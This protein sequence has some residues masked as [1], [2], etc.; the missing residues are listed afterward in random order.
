MLGVALLLLLLLCRLFKPSTSCLMHLKRTTLLLVPLLSELLLLLDS[1]VLLL[2]FMLALASFA[3]AGLAL[4]SF[5]AALLLLVT[6]MLVDACSGVDACCFCSV[7]LGSTCAHGH[8]VLVHELCCNTH[9]V[10]QL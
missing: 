4:L 3:A 2:A 6:S 10:Q 7:D 1:P 8:V 5:V 9:S